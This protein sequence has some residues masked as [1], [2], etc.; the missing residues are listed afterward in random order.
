MPQFFVAGGS[1]L[2]PL[3]REKFD[4]FSPGPGEPPYVMVEGVMDYFKLIWQDAH[5]YRVDP[6]YTLTLVAASFKALERGIKAPARV[7]PDEALRE[8]LSKLT[9]TS[10]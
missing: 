2:S 1:Y 9:V 8:K 6:D 3:G 10:S 5:L 4:L 7:V